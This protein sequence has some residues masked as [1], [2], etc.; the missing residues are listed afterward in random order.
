[1]VFFVSKPS[2]SF[3]PFAVTPNELGK[4]WGIDGRVYLPLLSYLN[5][6]KFGD[7]ECGEEMHFS[8]LDLI[9]HITKTRKLTAGTIIG[10]GT[11]SNKITD[12]NPSRG[13][14][15][16][17]EKRMFE[18]IQNNKVETEFMKFG[19]IIEIEMINPDNNVSIFG[20]ISQKVV[21][22]K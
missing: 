8:F 20:K 19:D 1:L 14:S 4:Y 13:F 11:I 6:K 18:K 16:I 21:K 22:K 9:E 15:C 12:K 3:S 10:S 5:G 7:P 17:A 2:T